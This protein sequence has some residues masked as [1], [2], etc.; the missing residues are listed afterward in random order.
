MDD[1]EHRIW[2]VRID[3]IDNDTLVR[4]C[5]DMLTGSRPM[6]IVTPNP[7]F[8]MMARSDES[9]RDVLNRADVSIPDGVGLRYAVAAQSNAR[10][11]HRH[12]GVDAVEMLAGIAHEHAVPFVLLGGFHP[13]L[14]RARQYFATQYPGIHCTAINPGFVPD[15]RGV[16]LVTQNVLH[17]L[18]V[19]DAKII[20]VGLGRGRGQGRGKQERY[21]HELAAKFP[22]AR[23]IIGVG[24]A[25]DYFGSAVSRA[26]KAWRS[27]GFEWLWR[28]GAEPW[29]IRR[30]GNAVV[31]FP[32]LVAWDTLK[33]GNFLAATRRVFHEISLLFR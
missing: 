28:I 11:Q 17:Q 13:F 18:Q 5:A 25:I 19:V 1:R 33:S 31:V 14:E 22:S 26:P 20:A 3:D 27:L 7:E 6:I 9:Y 10:L 24:G 32:I 29:R 16:D 4:R 8:L 2:G 23:I 15:E 30:V 12:I 21:L